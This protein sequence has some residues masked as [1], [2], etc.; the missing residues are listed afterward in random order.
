MRVQGLDRIEIMVRDLDRALAFFSGTLGMNF[1]ELDKTIARRDGIRAVTCHEAHLHLFEPIL[2]LPSSAPPPLRNLVEKLK[3]SEAVIV[4]L[5]F[6][7]DD[8]RQT[9]TDLTQQNIRIQHQFEPS[10]DYAS[11]GMDNFTQVVTLPDDTLGILMTFA[12]Y[13]RVQGVPSTLAIASSLTK[14]TTPPAT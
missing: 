5:A 9:A 12:R 10:H 2:P 3:T 14:V 4:A 13:D 7:V 11:M 8:A 1:V 6:A